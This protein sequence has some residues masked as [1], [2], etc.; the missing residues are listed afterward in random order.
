MARTSNQYTLLYTLCTAPTLAPTRVV[1]RITAGPFA[2]ATPR[3]LH[4]RNPAQATGGEQAPSLPPRQL[5][6]PA[7]H[8]HGNLANGH[9][10]SFPDE[11]HTSTETTASIQ[12]W[13]QKHGN[14]ATA[15][16]TDARLS[17]PAC[18]LTDA[19]LPL[20]SQ[21]VLAHARPG[22]RF[23]DAEAHRTEPTR[24]M[25]TRTTSEE[26]CEEASSRT[27]TTRIHR[28]SAAVSNDFS[29]I[30]RDEQNEALF[31]QEAGLGAVSVAKHA[32]A[33]TL[34]T[35]FLANRESS[36]TPDPFMRQVSQRECSIIIGLWL[37]WLRKT[38]NTKACNLG[39]MLS[40]LKSN[41]RT[42]NITSHFPS[43]ITED[44]FARTLKALGP[45]EDEQREILEERRDNVKLP[46]PPHL[47]WH[48]RDEIMNTLSSSSN[49][50]WDA[51]PA[52]DRIGGYMGVTLA[53]ES[54]Q[55]GVNWVF[56][57][58]S[59][60]IVIKTSD[61]RFQMGVGEAEADGSYANVREF[62]GE[63]ARNFLLQGGARHM[64]MSRIGKIREVRLDFMKDKMGKSSANMLIARRTPEEAKIVEDMGM[65]LC[66]SGT[67]NSDPFLT[68]YAKGK[69]GAVGRRMI[70]PTDCSSIVKQAART[71]S[72]PE[73]HFSLK[74]TRSG[75]TT[76]M[77]SAGADRDTIH[78]RTGHS[79]RSRVSD[80]HYNFQ[81]SSNAGGRGTS[82]GPAALSESSTFGVA[83]LTR[84]IP[85]EQGNATNTNESLTEG[86]SA[87]ETEQVISAATTHVQGGKLNERGR[88]HRVK[89]T[90]RARNKA[91][92]GNDAQVIQPERST[93]VSNI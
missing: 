72:L 28:L 17:L 89:R 58:N 79:T 14:N 81:A 93:G 48:L 71:A 53:A 75:A 82:E 45:T 50:G 69:K 63:D 88:G 21:S 76:A 36:S 83:Q 11:P 13:L 8:Q 61:I 10:G 59:T 57:K 29:V 20:I 52:M 62:K 78:S 3:A 27:N 51:A 33:W 80:S 47:V 46:M 49:G 5:D 64:C 23:Q 15:P 65:W 42:A 91:K 6:R 56:K 66:L 86:V 41:W 35:T 24:P 37:T 31:L 18:D 9:P 43:S 26:A 34:W 68:R 16:S 55:R 38:Q 7:S 4:Q 25:T 12:A 60:S 77:V 70:T 84:L 40:H 44:E 73:K 30:T 1:Q 19:V 54:A 90:I 67:T 39:P 87:A 92:I 85:S 22:S 32:K 74:S 2:T